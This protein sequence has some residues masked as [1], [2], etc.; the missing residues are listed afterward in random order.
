MWWADG[1]QGR[2]STGQWNRAIQTGQYAFVLDVERMAVTH[3]GTLGDSLSYADAARQGNAAWS[4]LPPAQL[5]LE[6]RV[7]GITYRCTRGGPALDHDGPRIIES[8]RFVQRADVTGLVF[9]SPD[10][11]TLQGESRFETCAWPD[12]LALLLEAYPALR[13]ISAADTFGRLG[14]GYG[15]DGTNHLDFP[16]TADELPTEFTLA[17]WVYLPPD[18]RATQLESWLVCVNGNEWVDGHFGL[19]LGSSGVPRAGLNIGGGRENCTCGGSHPC[20]RT[21]KGAGV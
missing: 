11:Q 20:G 6:V 10:G 4:Q 13:P 19:I 12:H 5:D 8:G 3:M 1:F 17:C 7:G 18:F 9:E 2:S 15:F 14:G 21:R 16:M